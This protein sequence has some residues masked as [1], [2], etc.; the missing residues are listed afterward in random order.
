M[1]VVQD[2]ELEGP[3]PER[4]A[5]ARERVLQEAVDDLKAEVRDLRAQLDAVT[6]ACERLRTG[7]AAVPAASSGIVIPPSQ[8]TG[9]AAALREGGK[10]AIRGTLGAVRR[11]WRV[12]DPAQRYVVATR[13]SPV[14]A[15]T[16]PVV[17]VVV[18]AETAAGAGADRLQELERQS[19]GRLEVAVWDR[20]RGTAELRGAGGGERRRVAA[21]SRDELL[22]VVSGSYLATLSGGGGSLPSTL[23]ETLQWL[24]SSEDLAYVRVLAGPTEDDGD[25]WPEMLLCRR[26][27]WQPEGIDLVALAGLAPRQPVVGKAVGLAG[28]LDA[29]VP[30]LATLGPGSGRVVCRTG[31]YDVWAGNRS[32][33]VLHPLRPLPRDAGP[34]ESE[35][36]A[37]MVVAV[38][39]VEGGAAAVL[40]AAVRELRGSARVVVAATAAERARSVRRALLLER[41]GATVYELGSALEPE[42][43]PSAIERIAARSAPGTVLVVGRDRRLDEAIARLRAGGAR[44]VALPA[45]G[46]AA[47]PMTDVRLV[48][49]A[50]PEAL[51]AAVGGPARPTPVPAGWLHPGAPPEVPAPLRERVRSELGVAANRFLVVTAGDLVA[52]ARPED[53]VMVADRLRREPIALALIGDGPLAGSVRDLASFLGVEALRI[54]VPQHPLEELVAAADLVLDP[55]FEPVV[56]PSV[57]AALAA[58]V[59]VVTAPGGGAERLI[60]EIGGGAVAGSLGD[61]DQLAE[62]VL[63]LRASGVRPSPE[64]ALAVLA[65]QR[66]AG[67]GA[68][69]RVLLGGAGPPGSAG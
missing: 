9:P 42:V 33:P 61:P 60:A 11:L 56:R 29:A 68:I 57:A 31:R 69:R 53:V 49:D 7:G 6:A 4:Q 43:W 65:G 37:V 38:S 27:L 8:G 18:A 24:I 32:G 66:Q 39:P 16:P 1:A 30:R 20:R 63:R 45:G 19:A 52:D 23:L 14:P 21:G 34:V 12:A 3:A 10:R 5:R 25:R 22:A 15:A 46:G 36:P 17:T 58:G 41:L 44:I 35:P 67:A 50:P 54:R 2:R 40:A 48:A 47:F 13:L 26:E 55:S 64:R 51:E 62:A 59:P 28:R